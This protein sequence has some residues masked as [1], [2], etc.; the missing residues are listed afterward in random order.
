MKGMRVVGLSFLIALVCGATA[1]VVQ[2]AP[3]EVGQ[4]VK[5]PAPTGTY[6]SANC[7]KLAE[8]E[9]GKKFVWMPVS[10]TEKQTFTG[11]GLESVLTT[12]GHPTIKCINANFA[13]E[14]TGP[15]TA[16]VTISF[17]GCTNPSEAQ[18]QSLGA[19]A[20]SLIET[21]PLEAELGFIK[22]Q[23]IEGK[24][25]IV[26]G[27]DLKPT[28]PFSDMI[29]YEC[30][31]SSE[32][33]HVEGS[34]I[35]KATPINRMTTTLNLKYLARKTGEQIP[36]SFEGGPKDTLMT[37]YTSGLETVGSGASSLNIK[38]ETGKETN[39]LEIKAK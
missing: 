36:E 6:S 15:K 39:L 11:S 19:P 23:I 17:Q 7:T 30:T 37:T 22:N 2:A 38:E 5:V 33:A 18:C 31:G 14:W 10:A 28:P 16:T 25:I 20:K 4:C 13:G 29:M 1:S 26:V 9:L 24:T 21:L 35:G 12:V 8:G 34:V 3:P 27:L 32:L